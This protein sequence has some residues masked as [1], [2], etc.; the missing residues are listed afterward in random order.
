[1][2]LLPR[3]VFMVCSGVNFTSNGPYKPRVT[4]VYLVTGEPLNSTGFFRWA[5]PGQPDNAGGNDNHPGED[6]G[7]MH[8][9]GGLNDI[10]CSAKI[11][12]ICEQELW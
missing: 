3:W 1:M 12:F 5:G 9:N 4:I 11:P 10:H 6:C 2:P 7:S 8:T